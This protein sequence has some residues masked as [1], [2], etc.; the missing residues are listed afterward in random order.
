MRLRLLNGCST[1]RDTDE[2]KGFG[3]ATSRAIWALL[4]EIKLKRCL[5]IFATLSR[6][7]LAVISHGSQHH[8]I[9]LESQEIREAAAD[10]NERITIG[11]WQK[12][13][14]PQLC[15]HVGIID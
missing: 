1:S 7:H 14:E 4:V 12:R 8:L 3:Q 11:H 6:V 9:N 13:T 2:L 5:S 10:L 15:Y